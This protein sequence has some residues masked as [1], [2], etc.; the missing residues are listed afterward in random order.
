MLARVS[1]TPSC[2]W[3]SPASTRVVC[4]ETVTEEFAPSEE[5]PSLPE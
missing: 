3:L 1:L 5:T 2:T 4:S